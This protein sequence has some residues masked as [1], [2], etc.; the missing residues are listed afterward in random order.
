LRGRREA[1][2]ADLRESL[3]LEARNPEASLTL[4]SLLSST[5]AKAEALAVYDAAL[6]AG[7]AAQGL[8]RLIREEREKLVTGRPAGP[9]GPNMPK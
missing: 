6:R 5:G 4:G 2:A 7:G 8:L 1:A 3:R 9:A